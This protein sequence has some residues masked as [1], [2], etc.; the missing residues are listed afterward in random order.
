MQTLVINGGEVIFTKF[1]KA[2]KYFEEEY[3]YEG[4]FWEIL[5]SSSDFEMLTDF[6]QSD[7]VDAELEYSEEEE[8]L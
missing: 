6:L 1:D 4:T 5:V 2:V 8:V 3:G 7:G